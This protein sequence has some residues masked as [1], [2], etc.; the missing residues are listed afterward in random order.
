MALPGRALPPQWPFVSADGFLGGFVRPSSTS[1]VPNAADTSGVFAGPL[2]GTAERLLC[3][4]PSAAPVLDRAGR[5][6]LLAHD[7]LGSC[8]ISLGRPDLPAAA[9]APLCTIP[10]SCAQLAWD[11]ERDRILAVVAEPGSDT[12]AVWS[13]RRD[14]RSEEDPELNEGHTGAQQVWEVDLQSG[15]NRVIGPRVGSVWELAVA[16]DGSLVCI[17]SDEAGEGGWYVAFVGRLDELSGDVQ[18]LYRPRQQVS[19]LTL[20][21]RTGRIAIAEAWCS[22]RGLLAGDAVVLKPNGTVERQLSELPGDITWLEWDERGRLFFAGFQ[23][24]DSVW[25]YLEPDGKVQATAD[26][27]G[28][29]GSPPLPSFALSSNGSVRLSIRSAESV[30]PEVVFLDDIGGEPVTWA[31]TPVT[32]PPDARVIEARW[33]S[34]DGVVI[35]GL[36][37]IPTSLPA[38]FTGGGSLVVIIH[39]GPTWLYH[40]EFDPGHAHRLLEAGFSVLLPNPRGSSG[41]GAAFAAANLGDPGGQELDDVLS[42]A[43]WAVT[44]GH[45]GPGRPAVMGASYGGYLSAMA[46]TSRAAAISAAVVVA[47]ISDFGSARNTGNNYRGYD[48]IFGGMPNEERVRRLCVDRSPIYVADSHVA[49]TLILHGDDDRCVPVGQAHELFSCLRSLGATVEMATYP[50]EGHQFSEPEHVE[51]MW[52]RTI[53]W[54]NRY[55]DPVGA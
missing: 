38:D 39:G 12:G 24:L 36:L 55:Q 26:A 4:V 35:E 29:L 46:A 2:N 9:P 8:R 34:T 16:P 27:Y 7:D 54:L 33:P 28:L 20:E 37:L 41:R 18:V 52:A 25:G 23:G 30:P 11:E 45:V 10:G 13:G 14:P 1:F 44:E 17:A 19:H 51:D 5:R 48:L 49:P 32:G 6:L 53:R 31:T 15:R 43:T 22:D 42:G 3:A 40:H 21:P 47:G 50:R